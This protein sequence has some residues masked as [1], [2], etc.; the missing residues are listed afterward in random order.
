V[1]YGTGV[2]ISDDGAIIADRQSLTAA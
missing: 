1:E 2:V